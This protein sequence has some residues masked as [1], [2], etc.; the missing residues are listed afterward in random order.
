MGELGG[1]HRHRIMIK[2]PVVAWKVARIEVVRQT[3]SDACTALAPIPFV[4]CGCQH[5][6]VHSARASH[7]TPSHA[8]VNVDMNSYVTWKR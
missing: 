4:K 1:G 2:W 5:F 3:K 7:P 6:R 8:S